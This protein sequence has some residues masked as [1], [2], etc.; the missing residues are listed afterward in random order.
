MEDLFLM[1]R[2]LIRKLFTYVCSQCTAVEDPISNVACLFL[3]GKLL[4]SFGVS[5]I[6]FFEN[7]VVFPYFYLTRE[8]RQY[9]Y[10]IASSIERNE[11]VPHRYRLCNGCIILTQYSGKTFDQKLVWRVLLESVA[12][13]KKHQD[14]TR[15]L[16]N[17]VI[18]RVLCRVHHTRDMMKCVYDMSD[19]LFSDA[20][21]SSGLQ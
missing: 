15:L 17:I 18:Q 14:C 2:D 21:Q 6:S 20:Q 11:T 4:V 13:S 10:S 3:N 1:N 7:G 8:Q 5:G 12:G 9:L 16:A 19:E